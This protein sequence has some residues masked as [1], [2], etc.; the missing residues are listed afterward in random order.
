MLARVLVLFHDAGRISERHRPAGEP[1]EPRAGGAMQILEGEC[2]QL[3]VAHIASSRPH[4]T[5]AKAARSRPSV[6][7]LRDS[8]SRN[9]VGDAYT[10]G[11][12]PERAPTFQS[13]L[14]VDGSFA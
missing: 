1:A 11:A 2:L 14:P 3:V 9:S 10:F 13:A 5:A 12:E 8:R 6:G 4:V 7:S